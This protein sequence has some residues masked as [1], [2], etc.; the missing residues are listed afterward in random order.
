MSTG[1]GMNHGKQRR[2]I[3]L[4]GQTEISHFCSNILIILG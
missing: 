2:D 4:L 3:G 1:D